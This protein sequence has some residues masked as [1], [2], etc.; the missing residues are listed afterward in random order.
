MPQNYGLY[1]KT[2]KT[3]CCF[4]LSPW[5]IIVHASIADFTA[6]TLSLIY[7]NLV[8][9]QSGRVTVLKYFKSTISLKD[10]ILISVSAMWQNEQKRIHRWEQLY[11]EFT[12]IY[13]L[14][15]Y[16]FYQESKAKRWS[17]QACAKCLNYNACMY[18]YF[19]KGSVNVLTV[20]VFCFFLRDCELS[21]PPCEKKGES[22]KEKG[23]K[24][25][26]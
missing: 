1:E 21:H 23:R 5:Q 20:T 9:K 17:L 13:T 8:R 19:C 4:K 11:L 6:K 12:W 26:C 15:F 18:N 24:I 22:E 3:R 7:L 10:W 2:F 25:V 16:Y 14:T